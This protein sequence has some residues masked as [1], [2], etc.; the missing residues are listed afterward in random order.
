VPADL[1]V[2]RARLGTWATQVVTVAADEAVS[3]IKR[4]PR[5][6]RGETLELVNSVR[7]RRDTKV[8]G[9]RRSVTLEAPVIQAVTTDQGARGHPIRPKRAGG[10]LVFHWP[11]VGRVVFFRHVNHPGNP[12]RP[13]WEAV[14]TDGCRQALRIAARRTRL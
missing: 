13:W 7:S 9:T 10:L 11:K 2:L 6:P 8:S 3:I 5:V 14:V 12:P 1:T 4:D